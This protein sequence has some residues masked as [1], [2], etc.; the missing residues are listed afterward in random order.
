MAYRLPHTDLVAA[1]ALLALSAVVFVVSGD[2]PAGQEGDPGAA[3][4]PRFIAAAIALFALL[5]A[6]DYLRSERE[7]LHEI[8]PG[9]TKRLVVVG[10]FPI[11][12][13]LL[14]PF[15][16]YLVTTIVFLAT[17]MWYSGARSIPIVAGSS[18]GITLALHY[19]FGVFF[20]VPLPEGIVPIARLLPSV[21]GVI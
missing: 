10:T 13:V 1:G 9:A 19:V 18:V 4:F 21:V 5:Q 3:F 14:M 7:Q 2:F 16:G 15:V 17:F 11:A 20:R 8:D 6:A 12:Y